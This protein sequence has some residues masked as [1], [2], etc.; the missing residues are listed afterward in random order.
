MK[1]LTLPGLQA[2]DEQIKAY[3]AQ[4]AANAA[5]GKITMLAVATLPAVADAQ[6]NIVYL[7]PNNKNGNN[8]KDEYVLIN[9][10][11]ELIGTTQADIDGKQDVISDLSAIRSGA[12]LGSTA[13]Q[14]SDVEG[15]TTSEIDSLFT[16]A[17]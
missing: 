15:I 6:T 1:V 3:I 9:G 17:T 11:F 4:V 13:L 8:V 5:A 12:S 7:V 2:Y 14:P 16:P 10:A